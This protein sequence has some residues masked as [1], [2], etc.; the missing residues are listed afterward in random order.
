M[1]QSFTII[2]ANSATRAVF[3]P[4]VSVAGMMMS[5]I[6]PIRATSDCFKDGGAGG[7]AQV[8]AAREIPSMPAMLRISRRD[9]VAD[10]SLFGGIVRAVMLLHRPRHSE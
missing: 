8:G 3:A 7:F 2:R 4:A 10:R 1:N 9:H 6:S 5:A